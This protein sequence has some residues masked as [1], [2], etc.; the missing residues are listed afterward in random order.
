[1]ISSWP[2]QV[3]NLT[4]NYQSNRKKSYKIS[5]KPL[6]ESIYFLHSFISVT[7]LSFR[8][9]TLEVRRTVNLILLAIVKTEVIKQN[10]AAQ[11]VNTVDTN[12]VWPQACAEKVILHILRIY[13]IN[14]VKTYL[15]AW[16][17]QTVTSAKMFTSMHCLPTWIGQ[18]NHPVFSFRTKV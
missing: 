3:W 9:F 6:S 2:D 14:F 13:L 1:M 16:W 18:L 10:R 4:S 8:V 7:F 5:L 17:C 15:I 11:N 12:N